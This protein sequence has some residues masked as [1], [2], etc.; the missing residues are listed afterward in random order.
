M[1]QDREL[2]T[3]CS[4]CEWPPCNTTEIEQKKSIVSHSIDYPVNVGKLDQKR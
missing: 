2:I 3:S 4:T 1:S